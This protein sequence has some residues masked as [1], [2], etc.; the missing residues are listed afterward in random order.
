LSTP[1]FF[2][3]DCNFLPDNPNVRAVFRKSEFKNRISHNDV[4]EGRP[5]TS[6]PAE[7]REENGGFM[8]GRSDLP[9]I[10]MAEGMERNMV[11]GD[12]QDH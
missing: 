11:P 3:A 9:L 2:T 12:S 5:P 1:S 10:K 8:L 4:N 7:R 6:L